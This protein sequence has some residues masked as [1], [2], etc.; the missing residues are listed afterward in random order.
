MLLN[1][2]LGC[3]HGAVVEIIQNLMVGFILFF[4]IFL[5]FAFC[6]FRTGCKVLGFIAA[7]VDSFVLP[8]LASIVSIAFS[9]VIYNKVVFVK[10]T[11]D[12]LLVAVLVDLIIDGT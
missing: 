6:S 7:V 11:P 8:L 10:A 1:L 4:T 9:V 5:P 2:G 12:D 3:S